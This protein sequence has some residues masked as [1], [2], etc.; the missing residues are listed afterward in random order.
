MVPKKSKVYIACSSNCKGK[1]VMSVCK[2][3]CIG[4]GLCAKN[5]PEGAI[6]MENNVAVIDYSKC[7]GCKTC[8]AKC[9]RKIIREF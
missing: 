7:T 5:C 6:V 8:M 9:P 2:V 3:G 1:D 4:C